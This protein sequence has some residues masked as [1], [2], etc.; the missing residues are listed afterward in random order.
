MMC[1]ALLN[2]ELKIRHQ[3]LTTPDTLALVNAGDLQ[4]LGR[5]KSLGFL[6]HV[7]EEF[8]K[9]NTLDDISV[10]TAIS[11]EE[12][13]FRRSFRLYLRPWDPE[14]AINAYRV[15]EELACHNERLDLSNAWILLAMSTPE[16]FSGNVSSDIFW[17]HKTIM[18]V[19][20]G[21]FARI[22]YG[23]IEKPET[24]QYD[25]STGKLEFFRGS[26]SP[27]VE[28]LVGRWISLE[29][30]SAMM[31]LALERPMTL[32]FIFG[33]VRKFGRCA[34]MIFDVRVK[35]H[36]Q[37]KVGDVMIECDTRNS[38]D[39][40]LKLGRVAG[41]LS[42]LQGAREHFCVLETGPSGAW[43]RSRNSG[44]ALRQIFDIDVFSPTKRSI[45]L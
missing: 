33:P 7:L 36:I 40:L 13:S 6:S 37:W 23:Q 27:V 15:F 26:E 8:M 29:Q 39:F 28:P 10:R 32:E 44:A 17:P 31:R 20:R 16:I 9:Y 12:E 19:A 18:E 3:Y 45:S 30:I 41:R 38:S 1:L 14:N 35:S 24:I 42:S 21:P 43:I 25:N 4:S 11:S 34:P 22:A 5:Q 2:H